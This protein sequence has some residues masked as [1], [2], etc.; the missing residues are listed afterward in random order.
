MSRPILQAARQLVGY[1]DALDVV[2]SS[3]APEPYK[4]M[5]DVHVAEL[6]AA[7][8]ATP[9]DGFCD[10]HRPT[11]HRQ[12]GAC[13]VCSRQEETAKVTK[14]ADLLATM[15][16]LPALPLALIGRWREWLGQV[17]EWRHG[18]AG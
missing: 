1:W 18:V 16:D 10:A 2:P 15:P 14:V 11:E 12:Y 6:R 4:A 7:L 8:E 5:M 3:E 13:W 17:T 9:R